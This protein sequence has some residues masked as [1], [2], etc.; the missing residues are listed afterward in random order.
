[1]AAP[2]SPPAESFRP[3]PAMIRPWHRSRLFWLG[4]PVLVFLLWG[5][6][7]FTGTDFLLSFHHGKGDLWGLVWGSGHYGVH[8]STPRF[9]G[10]GY[11]YS[12]DF[13]KDLWERGTVVFA[14]QWTYYSGLKEQSSVPDWHRLEVACW[15]VV[16]AYVALWFTLLILWQRRKARLMNPKVDTLP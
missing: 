2:Q 5:W 4:I 10:R 8:L 3:S 12:I 7:G 11:G 1:M 13:E 16:L 6:L 14:E 15:V 9:Q